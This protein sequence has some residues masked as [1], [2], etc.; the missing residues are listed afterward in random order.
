MEVAI[1]ADVGPGT[2]AAL[3]RA[4]ARDGYAVGLLSRR[5]ESSKPVAEEFFHAGKAL[6]VPADVTN[7]QS[8]LAAVAHIRG[9]WDRSLP[10]LERNVDLPIVLA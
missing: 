6:A 5:A 10:C 4:S 7:R 9:L 8:I 1:V 2:G 3:A